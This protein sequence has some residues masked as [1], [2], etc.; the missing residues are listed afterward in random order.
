MVIMEKWLDSKDLVIIELGA[1]SQ[2]SFLGVVESE[3][4]L[5]SDRFCSMTF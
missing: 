1:K 3:L 4:V 5:D 2:E